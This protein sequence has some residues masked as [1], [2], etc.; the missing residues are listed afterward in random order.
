MHVEAYASMHGHKLYC[1]AMRS[2]KLFTWQWKP[3]LLAVRCRKWNGSWRTFTREPVGVACHTFV[4]AIMCS[5]P[6][7]LSTSAL[8]SSDPS[9]VTTM[10]DAWL[11]QD[12]V[13][14]ALAKFNACVGNAVQGT[15]P[16][17]QPFSRLL[18]LPCGRYS[19]DRLL[20]DGSACEVLIRGLA[21]AGRTEEVRTTSPDVVAHLSPPCLRR[22]SV[23]SGGQ[24]A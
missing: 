6:C 1:S 13:D 23:W 3:R 15:E 2:A 19:K 7:L 11:Q 22:R 18:V 10:V 20:F 21:A 8:A 14:K 4:L 9:H 16:Q 17:H 24:V 5:R 12:G